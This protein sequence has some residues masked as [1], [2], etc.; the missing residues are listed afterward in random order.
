[1]CANISKADQSCYLYIKSIEDILWDILTFLKL[2]FVF[3]IDAFKS[4]LVELIN[5]EA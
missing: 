5:L 2:N 1:M 4:I 3:L